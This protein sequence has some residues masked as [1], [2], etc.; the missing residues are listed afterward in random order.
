MSLDD[1][2]HQT[3]VAAAT[4]AIRPLLFG[5][6]PRRHQEVAEAAVRAAKPFFDGTE[7][8]AAEAEQAR[9]TVGG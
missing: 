6:H 9:D 1:D 7:R 8:A 5:I 4:N 2:L 3:A